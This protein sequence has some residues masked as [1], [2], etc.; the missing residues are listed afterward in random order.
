MKNRLTI[1]LVI[2]QM[3]FSIAL[4]AAQQSYNFKLPETN[5]P[6]YGTWINEQYAGDF[7]WNAQKVVYLNWGIRMS[8]SSVG[9]GSSSQDYT[10][11]LVEKWNDAIGNSLYKE[12]LQARGVKLFELLKVSK[13]GNT[14]ELVQG[15]GFPNEND[16]D[17][18]IKSYRI[19]RKK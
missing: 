3:I 19:F 13:D 15:A 12:L 8:Y 1:C 4:C 9:D 2:V 17:P 6:I 10:F 7:F 5:E 18:N 16:L 11:I 14:L